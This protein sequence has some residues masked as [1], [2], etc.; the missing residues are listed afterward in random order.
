LTSN[1]QQPARTG[2]GASLTSAQLARIPREPESPAQTGDPALTLTTSMPGAPK[3]SV[4]MQVVAVRLTPEEKARIEKIA[5]ER[6]VTLSWVLR[7]GARI[8]ADD[9]TKWIQEHHGQEGHDDGLAP[10]A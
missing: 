3:I 2:G 7:E 8:Y 9:A 1:S 6:R 10:S 5:E 4:P